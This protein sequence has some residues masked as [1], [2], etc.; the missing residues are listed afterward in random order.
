MSAPT[1]PELTSFIRGLLCGVFIAIVVF[2]VGCINT[3]LI[4][5]KEGILK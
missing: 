3:V 4:C 1:A 2:V 5:Y